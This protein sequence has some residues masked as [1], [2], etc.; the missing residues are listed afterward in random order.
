M[1]TLETVRLIDD[2]NEK[3]K[4][5]AEGTL[6]IR[7]QKRLWALSEKIEKVQPKSG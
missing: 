1:F 2:L 5:F 4:K 7:Y 6:L 3:K